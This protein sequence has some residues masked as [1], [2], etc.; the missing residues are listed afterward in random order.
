MDHNSAPDLLCNHSPDP[1][2]STNKISNFPFDIESSAPLIP[3][4][5]ETPSQASEPDSS[6]TEPVET[7][8]I[9]E[10]LAKEASGRKDRGCRHV[11][12]GSVLSRS[13]IQTL[14]RR[15]ESVRALRKMESELRAALKPQGALGRLL[16]DRFWASALRLI[17]VARLEED[18]LA[19]QGIAA[20]NSASVPSLREGRL[21]V[22]VVPE[23]GDGSNDGPDETLASDSE[24]FRRLSLIARYDH[25]A[26]REMY[27]AMSLLMTMRSEGQTGLENLVRAT[28]GVKNG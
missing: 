6:R 15:G 22:L 8:G 16:F 17:L 2:K 28:A 9:A 23:D 26:A 19:P 13:L 12:H 27:R 7:S 14:E 25:L 5:A 21:P 18:G 11:V 3:T 24:L 4:S 10:S 20:K 1:E